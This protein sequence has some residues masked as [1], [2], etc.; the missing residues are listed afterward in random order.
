MR[1][2]LVQAH[3][4]ETLLAN[5]SFVTAQMLPR[6]ASAKPMASGCKGKMPRHPR[7]HPWA[8]LIP[9]LR[10]NQRAACWNF[11]SGVSFVQTKFH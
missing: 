10:A 9:G 2:Q 11:C 4:Q 7:S 1:Q 6:W 5:K 8:L 3:T